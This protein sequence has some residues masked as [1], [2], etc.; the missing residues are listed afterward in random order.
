MGRVEEAKAILQAGLQ[1][2]PSVLPS[3]WWHLYL[4]ASEYRPSHKAGGG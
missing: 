3:S 2:E 1:K 4:P